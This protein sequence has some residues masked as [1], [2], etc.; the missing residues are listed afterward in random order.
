M[1]WEVT[2]GARW[3]QVDDD[4]TMTFSDPVLKAMCAQQAAT[5]PWVAA[6]ATGPYAAPS[7]AKGAPGWVRL[8]TVVD[9]MH[10]ARLGNL[11]IAGDWPTAPDVD[12]DGV[13]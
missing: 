7:I 3:V 8:R 9:A 13:S 6:T 1:S 11:R 2:R 10:G 12:V 5:G 4:G